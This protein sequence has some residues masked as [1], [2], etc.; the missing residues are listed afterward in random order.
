MSNNFFR[1]DLKLG[2]S[3][4]VGSLTLALGVGFS[5]AAEISSSSIVNSLTPKPLT[6]SLSAAPVDTAK[7]AEDGKFID[8]VRNRRNS[9]VIGRRARKD[10]DHHQGQ[11]DHQS[12]Y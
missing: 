3:V 1:S 2:Y 9:F 5:Y 8:S 6:R 10:R 7:A 12:G 4:I 11:A